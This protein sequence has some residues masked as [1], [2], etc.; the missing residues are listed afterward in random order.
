M[1]SRGLEHN[2]KI[3]IPEFEDTFKWAALDMDPQRNKK[4]GWKTF[5][6]VLNNRIEFPTIIK[7]A[8][9]GRTMTTYVAKGE[10]NSEKYLK[11]FIQTKIESHVYGEL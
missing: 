10:Y 9:D 2:L 3:I 6:D 7:I 8:Q 5:R 4:F 1:F 11:Q